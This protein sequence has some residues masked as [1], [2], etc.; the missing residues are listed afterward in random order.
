MKSQS[1]IA[2]SSAES[3]D[4][5]SIEFQDV[6][7]DN[8]VGAITYFCV[9]TDKARKLGRNGGF[10]TYK[11][12]ADSDRQHVYLTVIENDR[13]GAWSRDLVDFAAIERCLP[14]DRAVPISAK[15]FIPSF[16]GRSANDPTFM[17]A[18]LRS[19]GLLGPVEN[20]P[21]LH[22]VIG[23]W[24]AWR[25]SMLRTEGVAY[26]PPS[27]AAKVPASEPTPINREELPTAPDAEE[28]IPVRKTR[29]LKLS[30]SAGV[31]K[32]AHTA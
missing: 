6:Q 31:G 21:Y 32:H 15:V 13:N 3:S 17:A 29:T 14:A 4:V 19:I 9:K 28:A 16:T 25:E 5:H 24:A 27:K 10:I 11:V 2:A 20:K 30:K 7:S 26:V 12:L 23:D 8:G 1:K 18:T 22:A